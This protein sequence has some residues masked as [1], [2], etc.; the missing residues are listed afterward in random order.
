MEE[1]S[2]E[3]TRAMLPAVRNIFVAELQRKGKRIHG[4]IREFIAAKGL[5]GH[6]VT[7]HRW[8]VDV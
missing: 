1:L 5:A 3:R 7:L 4:A 8:D 6:P 2:E